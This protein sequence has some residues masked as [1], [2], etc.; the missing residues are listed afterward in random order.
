[1]INLLNIAELRLVSLNPQ[2][3]QNV[4]S[5]FIILCAVQEG[6]PNKIE[7]FRNG[8]L[9]SSKNGQNHKIDL[10]EDSSMLTIYRVTPED[11]ANY[12]CIASNEVSSA[13]QFTVLTVRG[14][15][16]SI[17]YLHKMSP[18]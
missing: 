13:S 4:G 2:Q 15:S 10:L 18:S 1:M 12:S 16:L 17:Y 6:K 11:S 7:W 3:S 5:K 8:N 9:I 14:L